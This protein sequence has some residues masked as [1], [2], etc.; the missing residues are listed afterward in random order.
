MFAETSKILF[1]KEGRDV[2]NCA[3]GLMYSF[4]AS[5]LHFSQFLNGQLDAMTDED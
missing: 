4:E 5:V 3:L 1:C 2:I